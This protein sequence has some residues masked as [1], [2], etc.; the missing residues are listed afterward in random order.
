MLSVG[1]FLDVCKRRT[2]TQTDSNLARKVGITRAALAAYRKGASFPSDENMMRLAK[3]AN[4][5]VSAS[6]LLLNVWRSDGDV[7]NTYKTL[8][9]AHDPLF[10]DGLEEDT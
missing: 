6:L 10:D 2:H 5:D 1:E 4:L 7:Q 9:A 8:Y 3:R